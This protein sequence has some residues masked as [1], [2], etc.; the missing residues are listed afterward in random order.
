MLGPSCIQGILGAGQFTL[1]VAY[2]TSL[3]SKTKFRKFSANSLEFPEDHQQKLVCKKHY[4]VL[5]FVSEQVF[6]N[7]DYLQIFLQVCLPQHSF[8][9]GVLQN[10]HQGPN[11]LNNILRSFKMGAKLKCRSTRSGRLSSKSKD[12][13]VVV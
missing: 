11:L 7:L 2:P 4:S 5:G 12:Y 1:M 8:N 9:I 13:S 3:H 6:S 10:P